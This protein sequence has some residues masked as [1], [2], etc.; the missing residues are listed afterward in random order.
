MSLQCRSFEGHNTRFK[1]SSLK[2]GAFLK[3]SNFLH[4]KLVV[5]QLVLRRHPAG[6]KDDHLPAKV[7]IAC[8]HTRIQGET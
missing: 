8:S 3:R 4:E 2:L 5:V 1:P 6:V 7:V